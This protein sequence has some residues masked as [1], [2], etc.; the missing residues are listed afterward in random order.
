MTD[1]P[2]HPITLDRVFFVRTSVVAVTGHTPVDRAVVPGPENQLGINKIDEAKRVYQAVMRT[3]MN[4]E[5]DKS[6]PYSIDMECVALL[7]V[8]ETLAEEEAIRGVHITA[9]NV[10]YGA[11]REAVAWL[12][13]RGPFGSLTLGL[14]VLQFTNPAPETE[15][16]VKP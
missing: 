3:R 14:S 11:I 13:G 5:A 2:K 1:S 9:H 4:T 7:T 16:P 12:T 10:L 15:A 6:C 8:D